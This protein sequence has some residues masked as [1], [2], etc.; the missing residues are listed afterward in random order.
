[1]NGQRHRECGFKNVIPSERSESRNLAVAVAVKAPGTAGG[2]RYRG[3]AE[4][5]QPR[6][7]PSARPFGAAQG[8]STTDAQYERQGRGKTFALRLALFATLALLAAGDTPARAAPPGPTLPPMMTR[9][10]VAAADRGLAYLAK[11]QQPDGHLEAYAQGS[12]YPSVMTALAGLAFMAAGSTPEEGPYA[13]N[14]KKAMLYLLRIADPAVNKDGLI[15]GPGSEGRSMYGHG[16]GMLFLAQCYGMELN[17]PF[18]S[19]IRDVLERAVALTVKSQSPAG[20]WIYTPTGA[21]DEGSVTVTQLQALRACRNVGIKVPIECIQKAA[22]Y[23]KLCQNPDGGISYSL[24]SRGSSRPPISA[25][26]IACF[27]A[28]GVYDRQT[29][30]LGEEAETVEKLVRYVR[31]AVRIGQGGEGHYFYMHFYMAQAMYQRSGRDW[32]TYY[33]EVAKDLL[34]QQAT[35]GSW[36]GDGVGP[37]YGTA[38][39]CVILQLPYGYLPICQR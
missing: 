24:S 33:P 39:A 15:A 7:D 36:Q 19:R 9:D 26:A 20:G 22:K 11:V 32:E 1:M 38:L 14:V 28:A 37:V 4:R 3:P 12:G 2:C 6:R 34:R 18:E 27:Y 21:G 31:Q 29:G 13:A 25:A 16:F 30:G 8:D 17:T 23:L 10:I 35:D 5:P